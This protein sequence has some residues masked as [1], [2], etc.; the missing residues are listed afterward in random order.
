MP[1]IVALN[2]PGKRVI[3]TGNEAIARGAIEAA[4]QVAVGYPGTPSSEIMETLA[5]V[6]KE[7]G[8]HAEWAVN[9]KVAFDVAAGAAIVGARA[10]ATMKNAGVGW[11][12]DM[13]ATLPYTGV[14]GGL[15]LAVA[16]D[17]DAFYSST[18]QD[19][20]PLG[21]AVGVLVLEP[22]DQQ[23][24]KD[25]TKKA[26]DYSEMFEL[27]VMLRSVTRISHCSGDVTFG[28]IRKERNKVAFDKHWK[29][30]FRWNVYGPTEY[31]GKV[32]PAGRHGWLLDQLSKIKKYV[33]EIEFNRIEKGDS[34]L[35]IIA[36]G[37][38][39]SYV[40]DA[41]LKLN[42]KEKPWILKIGTPHPIPE[43]MLKDFLKNVE[44]VLIVEE[45]DPLVEEQVYFYMK[46][47]APEIPIYGKTKNR[48][49][50]PYGELGIA[51]VVEAVAKFLGLQLPCKSEERIRIKEEV[52]KLIAPRS[53]ALCPGCPHLGTYWALRHALLKVTAKYKD[54]MKGV[55]IINGDIG[56][57]EQGG[58]G[59]FA[60]AIKP[61]FSTE[62]VRYE[63]TNPY[64][65][66]D[67]N[68]IMGGGIGLAQGEYHAGY[69]DGPIIAV[70]GDSTFFHAC[71]PA[72]LNAT[73]N[74]AAIT[75][76]VMDN[77]WTAMTGHQPSPASGYTA[78]FEPTKRFNVEEVAKA[79]GVEKVWVVDPY[80]LKEIEE[81]V[82]KAIEESL[83]N[84][85]TTLVVAKRECALQVLRR[86]RREKKP[87]PK[88]TVDETKCVGC[89]RC[90]QLGCPAIGFN[91]EKGKAWID[92]ILCVGCGMCAQICPVK[93]I[94]RRE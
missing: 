10:I 52:S 34:K 12:M 37:I 63:I 66:L 93:A 68:Y 90:T 1:H 51:Q 57:Y 32:G 35:G 83:E 62:S 87:I 23:E 80:N 47:Y 74:K 2:E 39:Y 44:K 7:L 59:I 75:F 40:K 36:S 64:E 42:P 33:N 21:K 60:K 85:V 69:R 9:E 72:L 48:M 54:R 30:P 53:S 91:K 22:C 89:R 4:V 86:L 49:L 46:D 88:Y 27:P 67:T 94:L 16:D 25:M 3:L 6:A 56:C 82:A 26:F 50:K 58:Y 71:M 77:S 38:G 31:G 20:R 61:S 45:G 92:Q 65:I 24:A 84:K 55:W 43:K 11:I 5:E 28:E 15:V 41:L 70:A 73:F 13:F 81:V 29:L 8:F 76:I 17:P 19:T 18:E 79:L 78:T 14:R